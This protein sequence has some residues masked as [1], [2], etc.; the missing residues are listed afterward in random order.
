MDEDSIPE[1]LPELMRYTDGYNTDEHVEKAVFWAFKIQYDV[2]SKHNGHV[3]DAESP[4]DYFV[5]DLT[6]PDTRASSISSDFVFENNIVS[7]L[8][9]YE[10]NNHVVKWSQDRVSYGQGLSS[11]NV[12]F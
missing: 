12:L 8:T 1:S 7:R 11:H 6:L 2:I 4:L 5:D 10:I 9:N 3:Y